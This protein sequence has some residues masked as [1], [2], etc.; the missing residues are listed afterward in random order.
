VTHV[1]EKLMRSESKARRRDI[2]VQRRRVHIMQ[3]VA[4]RMSDSASSDLLPANGTTVKS[5]P[6]SHNE[7]ITRTT[8]A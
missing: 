6:A 7:A 1:A 5:E 2:V 4:I 8:N 3:S